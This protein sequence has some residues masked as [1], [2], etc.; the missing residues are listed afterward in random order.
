[1]VHSFHSLH[2]LDYCVDPAMHYRNMPLHFMK[3]IMRIDHQIPI[4]PQ[5]TNQR[6]RA[7]P[8]DE[9]KSRPHTALRTPRTS[10]LV[11]KKTRTRNGLRGALSRAR[12]TECQR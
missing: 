10:S 7:T 9:R 2:E 4:V 6:L 8:P 12:K 11:L 3:V 1:M 5:V